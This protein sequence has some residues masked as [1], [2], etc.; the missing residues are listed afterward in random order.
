LTSTIDRTAIEEVK[1]NGF[2]FTFYWHILSVF[3][4]SFIFR[5]TKKPRE[6]IV[7]VKTH[8]RGFVLQGIFEVSA[9]LLQMLAIENAFQLNANVLYIKSITLIQLLISTVFGLWLFKEKNA[10]NK[11]AGAIIMVAGATIIILSRK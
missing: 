7:Q 9:F 10:V 2:T 5:N 11:L 3:L 8:F 6:Y 1:N 4:F